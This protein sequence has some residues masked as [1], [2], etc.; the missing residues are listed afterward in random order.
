MTNKRHKVRYRNTVSIVSDILDGRRRVLTLVFL[1]L[2]APHAVDIFLGF[3]VW[4]ESNS[5]SAEEGRGTIGLDIGVE[6]LNFV[7]QFSPVMFSKLTI[8]KMLVY[9]I[10]T[11]RNEKIS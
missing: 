7:Q 11:G 10:G 3:L 4:D 8:G 2:Q 9:Y 6:N 1:C 5:R